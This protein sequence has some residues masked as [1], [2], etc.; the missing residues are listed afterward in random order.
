MNDTVF[1]ISDAH[2]GL[3]GSQTERRQRHLISF[4]KTVVSPQASHLFILGDFF[5]FWIEYKYAIQ[6]AH[7]QMLHELRSLVEKN[8]AIH[9]CSGNHD[10][11]LG[12]FLKRDIGITLSDE[13]CCVILQGRRVCCLH[14]DGMLGSADWGY[15]LLR[16]VLRNRLN[17]RIYKLLHPSI[18]IPL[19]L[20][21]SRASRRQKFNEYTQH[22]QL[23]YRQRARAILSSGFD[24]VIFSHTH[25]PEINNI[26]S[27][28][29]CNTG[30]WLTHNSYAK[31]EHGELTLWSYDES[32]G[33]QAIE[34]HFLNED[35]KLS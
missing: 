31:L 7:F 22:R 3:I 6:P 29:V 25:F 21:V 18:A 17:Q 23:L 1:F 28:V 14:G 33:S 35:N 26:G 10:F 27:A 9:Y 30:D 16:K 12:D 32:T 19:G 11:A 2:L 24:M 5:D 13:R 34:S 4:L 8:I 15:R 20:L